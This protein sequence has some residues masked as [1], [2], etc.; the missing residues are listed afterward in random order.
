MARRGTEEGATSFFNS[1]PMC[2]VFCCFEGGRWGRGGLT[3]SAGLETV[4][5]EPG[6][7][8]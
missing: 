6:A 3:R 5:K 7:V 8:G 2:T 4:D 1:T